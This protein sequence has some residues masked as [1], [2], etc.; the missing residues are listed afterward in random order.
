MI[1]L[2]QYILDLDGDYQRTVVIYGMCVFV[3]SLEVNIH[4]QQETLGKQTLNVLD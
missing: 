3:T 2:T 1:F 4:E